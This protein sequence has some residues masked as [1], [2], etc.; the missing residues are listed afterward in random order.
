VTTG[1]KIDP[2]LLGTLQ[3]G[4]LDAA[5]EMLMHI[6]DTRDAAMRLAARKRLTLPGPILKAEVLGLSGLAYELAQLQGEVLSRVLGIRRRHASVVQQRVEAALGVGVPEAPSASLPGRGK[7]TEFALPF[8]VKNGLKVAGVLGGSLKDG[9]LV[10]SEGTKHV[11]SATL[12]LPSVLDAAGTL[13]AGTVTLLT[14]AVKCDSAKPGDRLQGLY[15]VTVGGAPVL[16]LH[17]DIQVV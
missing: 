7:G 10:D 1:G 8:R 5:A 11:A 2:D 12:R 6:H 9:V 4:T 16:C 17:L 15:T 3:Q 13:P 14:L